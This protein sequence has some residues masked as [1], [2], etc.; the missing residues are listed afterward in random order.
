[1][2]KVVKYWGW[3][4]GIFTERVNK[5]MKSRCGGQ[6]IRNTLRTNIGQGGNGRACA[7]RVKTGKVCIVY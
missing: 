2:T 4:A 6:V 1:M 3:G 5:K 7:G